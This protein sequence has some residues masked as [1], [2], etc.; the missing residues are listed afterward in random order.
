MG[1]HD[2]RPERIELEGRSKGLQ[3][4]FASFW[5]LVESKDSHST[6]LFWMN[7]G[8]LHPVAQMDLIAFFNSLANENQL[9]IQH[10]HRFSKYHNLSGVHAMYIRVNGN[11]LCQAI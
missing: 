3:W 11:L 9:I 5:S 8:S 6:V 1:K 10:T 2:K 7:Q 4:F